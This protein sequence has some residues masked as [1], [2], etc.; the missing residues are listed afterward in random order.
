MALA[1]KKMVGLIKGKVVV[2][3]LIL[4]DT[5]VVVSGVIQKTT[6]ERE[7]YQRRHSRL[8]QGLECIPRS[9]PVVGIVGLS[10]PAPLFGLGEPNICI[11]L[12]CFIRIVVVV[13]CGIPTFKY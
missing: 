7:T 5:Q 6:N 2:N 10:R 8:F 11:H 13:V 3:L 4:E 12:V 1:F 9:L